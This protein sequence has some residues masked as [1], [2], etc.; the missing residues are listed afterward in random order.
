M[1]GDD[2]APRGEKRTSV[3]KGHR[4]VRG[5]AKAKAVPFV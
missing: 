1:K 3:P 2:F 5:T 4:I